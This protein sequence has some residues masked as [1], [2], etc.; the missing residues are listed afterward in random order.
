MVGFCSIVSKMLYKTN[1]RRLLPLICFY[2]MIKE[3]KVA[4]KFADE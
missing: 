4:E 1:D 3:K 2:Y